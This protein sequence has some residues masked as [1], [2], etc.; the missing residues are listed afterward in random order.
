MKK[1]HTKRSHGGRVQRQWG[2]EAIA[3]KSEQWWPAKTGTN[4]RLQIT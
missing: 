4:R 3:Q 2:I 1:T